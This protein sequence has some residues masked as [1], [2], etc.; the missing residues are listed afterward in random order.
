MV[1]GSGKRLGRACKVSGVASGIP[2]LL[3]RLA[4]RKN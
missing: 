2:K 3:A 4:A 1:V